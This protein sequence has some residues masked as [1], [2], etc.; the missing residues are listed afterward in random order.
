MSADD[1]YA[2]DMRDWH[3]EDDKPER[4]IF[5]APT[6]PYDVAKKFYATH[7]RTDGRALVWW[8]ANWMRWN[9]THWHEIDA[10]ELRSDIYDILDAVDYK[11]PIK[12][13]GVIVGWERLPLDP[14]RH[15]VA[16]VMDSIAAIG[17][18]P[19]QIDPPSW[20]E[21]HGAYDSV[22]A[23]VISCT[24]GLLDL[25]T[26]QLG[27][28]TPALFNVVSVPF[29][30]DAKAAEPKA[31]L[32]FLASV[33]GDDEQ[34]KA[35]L[36]EYF[37]YVLSG[38]T[39]M[40]KMLLLIGPTR[41]GKGTIGRILTA[42]I[43]SGNVAG[44]T[45]ASLG[46]NFGLSPLLGKPL[47]IIS[48]ARLGNT[49]SHVVVERLLTITGEDMLTVDR[50]YRE[51]WSGK[52]NAR[53]VVISNEL[54]KFRDSSAAIA[55]RLLILQQTKSF[56]HKEDRTLDRRLSAE[57][58]GILLWALEGLDRLTKNGVFTVPE[59]SDEATALMADMTSPVSA[60]L[61]DRTKVKVDGEIGREQL[62]AAWRCWASEN[63]HYSGSQAGFGRDLHAAAPYVKTIQHRVGGKRVRQ[64]LGLVLLC[65]TCGEE[66]VT[67]ESA[68]AAQCAE[69]RVTQDDNF[70]A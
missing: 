36:Q 38:R 50:K 17:H 52:L 12:E 58:P 69:C 61:R 31:W 37:G 66:L 2:E 53:F 4:E 32:D 5:P 35:L 54:P 15:K 22:A 64:Y 3:A 65:D 23:Q 63:G 67:V 48:D 18:L 13:K 59:S 10:A 68:G 1:D 55:Y 45:L 26:R 51:Q 43:G 24:N 33:W 34:S 19:S 47:A 56:L 29:D 62:F 42:L 57:L 25:S 21:V 7:R 27:D 11:K 14:N 6:A 28:H 39:D 8:R 30:Y 60:F 20:I 46:T 44:P 16:D 40:Q 41:S 9:E 49:S 70:W